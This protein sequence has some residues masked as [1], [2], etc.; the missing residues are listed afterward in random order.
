MKTSEFCF[1]LTGTCVVL[2]L[3]LLIVIWAFKVQEI[4]PFIIGI[5]VIGF[6]ALVI[7][8]ISSIWE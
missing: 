2:I 3:A 1:K 7:G 8:I 4:V 6:I 5:G